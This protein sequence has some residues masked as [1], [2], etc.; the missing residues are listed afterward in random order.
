MEI[1]ASNI[2]IKKRVLADL[3]RKI[4]QLMIAQDGGGET[5]ISVEMETPKGNMNEMIDSREEAEAEAAKEGGGGEITLEEKFPGESEEEDEGS[6]S[7][8]KKM[9]AFFAERPEPLPGKKTAMMGLSS[10][11]ASKPPA[12]KR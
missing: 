9:K 12:R 1:E 8:E 6:L 11:L 4:Q 3:L 10:A 5:E 7:L 2:D